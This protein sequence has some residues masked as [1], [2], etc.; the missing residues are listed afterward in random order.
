MTNV[1]KI[2]QL[3]VELKPMLIHHVWVNAAGL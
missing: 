1:P 3:M 2:T